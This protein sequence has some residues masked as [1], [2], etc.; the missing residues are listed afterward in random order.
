VAGLGAVGVLAVPLRCGDTTGALSLWSARVG[1]F[2][3]STRALAELFA[4]HA[5]LAVGHA[6][7]VAEMERAIDRR[8]LIGQAKG[9]LM[10]THG[11]DAGQAFRMLRQRSQDTN[12]KLVDVARQVM[13]ELRGGA[14]SAPR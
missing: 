8:D 9:A 11:V 7:R 4:D 2:P 14:G 3:E 5:R 6:A 10:V 13:S 12:V 1:T